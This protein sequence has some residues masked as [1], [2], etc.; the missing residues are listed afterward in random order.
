M[1]WEGVPQQWRWPK[2]SQVS[3]KR[4]IQK[5]VTGGLKPG[6]NHCARP[7]VQRYSL[8][9]AKRWMP[10]ALTVLLKNSEFFAASLSG[11]EVP[12]SDLL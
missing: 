11:L 9:S 3:C 10:H 12:V 7:D 5:L 8:L 6:R 2:R 4:V 1:T